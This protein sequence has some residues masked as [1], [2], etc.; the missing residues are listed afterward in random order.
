MKLVTWAEFL[1]LP[2]GTI[3]SNYEPRIVTGLYRKGQ[4]LRRSG[5]DEPI[6]FYY[7]DLLGDVDDDGDLCGP[8]DWGRD[9]MYGYDG[10]LLMV[11]EAEDVKTLVDLL[12][13]KSHEADGRITAADEPT[14]TTRTQDPRQPA[15]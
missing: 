13:G 7:V 4:T 10:R 15:G 5:D 6:D 11:Y 14:E 1:N 3:Y 8:G 12:Q 9:G 2:V